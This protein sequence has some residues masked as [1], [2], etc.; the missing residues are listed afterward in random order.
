MKEKEKDKSQEDYG[1]WMVV[2]RKKVNSKTKPVQHLLEMNHTANV[3]LTQ[4]SSAT[5]AKSRVAG[6]YGRNGK[7]KALHTQSAMSQKETNVMA[8][9]SQ[10]QPK[11]GKGTKDKGVRAKSN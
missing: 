4:T 2:S 3:Q 8:M 7:R 10:S 5:A 11:I 6:Q 1:E 9:S